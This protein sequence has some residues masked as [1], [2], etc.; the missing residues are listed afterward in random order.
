MDNIIE[1][2]IIRDFTP[3]D[4]AMVEEF[5]DQMGGETRALF[6][7]DDGNRHNAMNYFK[8]NVKNIKYCLAEYEGR[9]TGYVFMWDINTMVPWLGIAVR[10]EF[11][12]RHLGR[13]LISHMADYAK[14]N[15][16]GGIMLTTHIIN[17]AAQSL[18]ERMGF[19]C[20]GMQTG[21]EALYF[22]RF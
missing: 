1:S 16:K 5:F 4:K 6:N 7:R 13:R 11:K 14:E 3:S 9:M 12:G 2:M 22:L 8:G 18:Y 15:G 21:S 10:E 19:K 17:L 20:L